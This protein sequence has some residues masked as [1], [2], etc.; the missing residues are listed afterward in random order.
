MAAI[1]KTYV[2]TIEEYLEIKTWMENFTRTLPNGMVL[3]GSNF[4]YNIVNPYD[5][6]PCETGYPVMNTSSTMD[7]FL[8][9]ECP[10]K[11]IQDRMKSVYS[12]DYYNSVKN[13]TSDFDTF[14]RP[15]SGKHLKLIRKPIRHSPYKLYSD[16]LKKHV[17]D[18]YYVY[19]ILPNGNYSWYYE[20]YDHWAMEGELTCG[21][22]SSDALL[23]VGSLKALTRVVKRWNLPVGSRVCFHG[24]RHFGMDGEFLVTK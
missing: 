14:V 8:I 13:G 10:I 19:V 15:E 1:D 5:V 20:D 6:F 4:M 9:K 16:Y 3:H 2:K 24:L 17:Q 21:N 18:K 12:E 11:L 22:F 23:N 7:Y